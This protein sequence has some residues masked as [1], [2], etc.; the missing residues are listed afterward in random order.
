M[1]E[2]DGFLRGEMKK[3]LLKGPPF[4]TQLCAVAVVVVQRGINQRRKKNG[5]DEIDDFPDSRLGVLPDWNDFPA[6]QE[7]LVFGESLVR[8]NILL[9]PPWRI[10]CS[11]ASVRKTAAVLPSPRSPVLCKYTHAISTACSNSSD[12]RSTASTPHYSSEKPTGAKSS[13]GAERKSRHA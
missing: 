8:R 3:A 5:T 13:S 12:D 11:I 2:R 4:R 6:F 9:R 10:I 7:G 1:T